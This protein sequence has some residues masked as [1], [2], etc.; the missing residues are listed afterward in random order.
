M[1]KVFKIHILDVGR[2]DSIILQFEN[3]RTYLI[4]SNEVDGKTIP[5]EYL[6]RALCV[7]ELE[8]VVATHIHIDHVHGLQRVIENIPTRQVWLSGYHLTNET[9]GNLLL[10]LRRNSDV[11]VQFPRSGMVVAEGKDRIQVLAPPP[12][13]RKGMHSDANNASIVLKVTI[14]NEE[15]RTSTNAILG[16]DA[17]LA[18]WAYILEEH[19]WK[20]Q[21]DLLKVSHHG[22]DYGTYKDVLAAIRPKYAVITVGTNP[23]GH[24]EQCALSFLQ[25]ATSTRVL[26]TDRDGT[27]VFESDGT[28]W[29]Y[30]R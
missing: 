20:M 6:T 17:E 26:R 28:G 21:A 12:N 13:L 15:K 19:Q 25:G 8:T 5:F 18:S 30:V 27:C 29:E 11:R 24:P 23:Y 1:K 2:G 4:D 14:T 22:S 10:A 16:A 9:Y 7:T 3:G